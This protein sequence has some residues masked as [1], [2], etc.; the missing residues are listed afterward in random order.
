MEC[1][2]NELMEVLRT[3]L[4][5]VTLKGCSQD[6]IYLFGSRLYGNARADSD[7]DFIITVRGPYFPG[8]RLIENE[9]QSFHC[10]LNFQKLNINLLHKDFFQAMLEDNIIWI[11]MLMFLPNE[12]IWQENTKY[13][14]QIKKCC[15]RKAIFAV[16]VK[17]VAPNK[18][19]CQSP[20]CKS[21]EALERR[22]L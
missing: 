10:F 11:V 18:L 2:S 12:C 20:L 13:K 3:E 7:W 19:G 16:H 4:E 17:Q 21:E 15:L 14:F 9:V 1:S 8:P 5:R 6:N 22:R